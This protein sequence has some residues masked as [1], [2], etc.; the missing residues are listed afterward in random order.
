[1]KKWELIKLLQ[2]FTDDVEIYVLDCQSMPLD[3]KHIDYI[4]IT[5]EEQTRIEIVPM[6]SHQEDKRAIQ[7]GD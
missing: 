4:P 1:M 3:I 7:L 6:G 2:P 5:D